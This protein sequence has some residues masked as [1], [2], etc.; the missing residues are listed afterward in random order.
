MKTALR[1]RF[2]AELDGLSAPAARI[3]WLIAIALTA[4]VFLVFS[5]R[6]TV[7]KSRDTAAPAPLLTIPDRRQQLAL[8]DE[9]ELR[10]SAPL[11]LPTRWNYASRLNEDAR[12]KPPDSAGS[13]IDD[14]AVLPPLYA[15]ADT[16]PAFTQINSPAPPA[17]ADLLPV[18]LWHPGRTFG[19][20]PPAPD[21]LPPKRAGFL[22]VEHIDTGSILF[23]EPLPEIPALF[24]DGDAASDWTPAAFSI[25][26]DR[27]G[28][29]GAP[30]A[31]PW[32]GVKAGTG[33][34]A[35]DNA[36]RAF[37]AS[38][39]FLARLPQGKFRVSFGP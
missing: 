20:H 26:I 9:I 32:I 7:K 16:P 24:S 31:I 21:A 36:L 22:R 6:I 8:N 37:L 38:P 19:M 23:E 27:L 1:Q 11:Y 3:A 39:D 35:I 18:R 33:N 5:P 4:G 10:D 28:I 12:K 30:V 13:G 15:R 17:V 2:A 14:D 29:V 25:W 34:T